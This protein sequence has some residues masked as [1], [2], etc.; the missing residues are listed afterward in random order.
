VMLNQMASTMGWDLDF[1]QISPSEEIKL[2]EEKIE[3]KEA[4]K[5]EIRN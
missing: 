2:I 4:K 5:L 1:K 3:F